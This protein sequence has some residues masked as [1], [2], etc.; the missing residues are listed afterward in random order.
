MVLGDALPVNP[1]NADAGI[2]QRLLLEKFRPSDLKLNTGGPPGRCGVKPERMGTSSTALPVGTMIGAV[3][4]PRTSAALATGRYSYRSALKL[5]VA[6][7]NEPAQHHGSDDDYPR[8][9]VKN[10]L[11]G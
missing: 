9:C 2:R 5:L 4:L 11:E 8:P 3:S 7:V 1:K 6:H 10:A